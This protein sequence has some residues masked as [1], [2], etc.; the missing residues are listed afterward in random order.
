MSKYIG[1][2]ILFILLT[3]CEKELDFKYHDVESQFV[4]EGIL[5][6]QG[7]E[8]SLAYTIPMNEPLNQVPI[9]DAVVSLTDLTE[10]KTYNLSFEEGKYRNPVGGVPSHN[11]ELEVIHE[12]KSY[13]SANVM[14]KGVEILELKLQWIKMPYDHV[15]ILEIVSTTSE[16]NGTCYWTRI[17]KNGEPYKWLIS[18]GSGAVDGILSQTTFTTRMNPTDPDDKDNLKEGDVLSVTVWPISLE[19][20][21]YLVG[22]TSDS[23]GP[24][25]FTG[26]FCLGYF[27]AA[28]GSLSSI[29]FDPDQIP[30]PK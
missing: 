15:A 6:D 1:I 11:Y 22:I 17:Y 14:R 21:D 19:M 9:K 4:I 23:N 13:K 30:F 29:R 8:V 25:M 28:E 24:Q 3:S 16:I 18:H 7:S 2:S 10:S 12:G 5:T 26:D 20:Y 27:M